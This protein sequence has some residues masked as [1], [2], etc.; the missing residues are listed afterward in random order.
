MVKV[1]G[2][3]VE[4]SQRWE[5]GGKKDGAEEDRKRT[6]VPCLKNNNQ[7]AIKVAQQAAS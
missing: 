5:R 1:T 4:K 2:G 6:E 3:R 7:T